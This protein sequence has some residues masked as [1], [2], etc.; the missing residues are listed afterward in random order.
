MEADEKS[1][2]KQAYNK[3]AEHRDKTDIASWKSEEREQFLKRMQ[4]ESRRTL[5]EIGAG[6][7]RDSLYFQKNG[8]NVTAID[9]SE[10]MV[11]LCRNKGLQAQVMDFYRLDFPQG[12]FDKSAC[13]CIYNSDE[14]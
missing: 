5:L 7:G 9:F 8:L 11:R 1:A 14:I 6:T 12:S 3:F 4:Q 13:S 2:L 10:E